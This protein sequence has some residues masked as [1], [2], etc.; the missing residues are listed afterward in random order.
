MA[1]I[2]DQTRPDQTRPDHYS[3]FYSDK[4]YTIHYSDKALTSAYKVVKILR[5]YLSFDSAIDIGCG[6][7]QVL[8]ACSETGTSIIR[9]VDGPWVKK[10]LLMIPSECF[11]QYDL[12][13][14]NLRE[15]IPEKNFDLTISSEVAEHIDTQDTETFMDNLTSFSDVILFSA[16]IPGQGGTHHVNEQWPSYWIE[17]FSAR[18][19]VPVDCIRPRIWDDRVIR[20][21][22]RQNLVLFVKEDKLGNYP[23]INSEA[24]K[25][26]L[27]LAHPDMF[28]LK[29]DAAE[30]S[31][32]GFLSLCKVILSAIF[33]L[34]PA[35]I[36]AVKRKL[37]A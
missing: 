5:E 15:K 12:S 31:K 28:K 16:A 3:A 13:Q 26:V 33:Y 19:F 36:R 1:A 30:V 32:M 29:V 7:G 20:T 6:V 18:G 35:F 2:I 10:E 24:G 25:K 8:K 22:Y 4:F 21:D 17:K 14:P 37:F 23:S 11:S 34:I 9:G 27:D